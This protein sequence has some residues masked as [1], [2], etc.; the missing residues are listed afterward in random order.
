MSNSVLL[1]ALLIVF[2]KNLITSHSTVGKFP[3]SLGRAIGVSV[4]EFVYITFLYI[5]S[6]YYIEGLSKNLFKLESSIA[7][8]LIIFAYYLISL[9]LYK[10]LDGK[11]LIDA[12]L[13]KTE[14]DNPLYKNRKEL[15]NQLAA[16]ELKEAFFVS[17]IY[18]ALIFLT[19]ALLVVGAIIVE[20]SE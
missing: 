19:T 6:A 7:T 11:G 1:T 16:T 13:N 18:F 8:G 3:A 10:Y 14:K 12:E 5:L 4:F 17:I 2:I 20:N 9:F 15:K